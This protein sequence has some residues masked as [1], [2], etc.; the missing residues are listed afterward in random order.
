MLSGRVSR[1]TRRKLRPDN[2]YHKFGVDFETGNWAI[3]IFRCASSVVRVCPLRPPLPPRS[4]YE[5]DVNINADFDL[6]HSSS[7]SAKNALKQCKLWTHQV[8]MSVYGSTLG[9]P[10]LQQIRECVEEF[11]E[12]ATPQDPY[13]QSCIPELVQQLRLGVQVTDDGA[14][15]ADIGWGRR[16][17]TGGGGGS[18]LGVVSKLAPAAAPRCITRRS[19]LTCRRP[20]SAT[21][22]IDGR[23]AMASRRVC[24]I[25]TISPCGP[26]PDSRPFDFGASRL[27]DSFRQTLAPHVVGGGGASPAAQAPQF[28]SRSPW[29]VLASVVRARSPRGCVG[30]CSPPPDVAQQGREDQPRKVPPRHL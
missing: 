17:F 1:K 22:T 12:T 14:D 26:L 23:L 29:I 27:Q 13:F 2:I 25:P 9:P 11:F 8:L 4:V 21:G 20:P 28:T 15:Q 19:Y 10:R 5:K 16:L 30:R 24:T 18:G 7:N 3:R 6:C